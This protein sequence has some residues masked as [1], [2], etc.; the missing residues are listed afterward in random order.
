[1]RIQEL[2]I[3]AVLMCAASMSCQ[4]TSQADNFSGQ[5]QKVPF[6]GQP[7]PGPSPELFAPGLVSR[8]YHELGITISPSG[9][10]CFY[11]TANNKYPQYVIIR[12]KRDGEAWLAPEVA[13]FSGYYSDYRP[14]FSPDGTR[15]FFSSVRPLPG[16]TVQNS[17]HDIWVTEKKGQSWSDPIHLG[18]VLNSA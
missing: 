7:T 14:Y 17:S 3:L 9:D 18:F 8:G 10:E 2:I 11:V 4:N 16:D 13:S 5:E 6:L 1:M 15:L 12:V